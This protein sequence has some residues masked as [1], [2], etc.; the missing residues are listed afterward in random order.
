MSKSD[1]FFKAVQSGDT[2]RVRALLSLDPALVRAKDAE[3]K[4]RPW[5]NTPANRDTRRLPACSTTPQQG[6]PR[7]QRSPRYVSVVADVKHYLRLLRM[8]C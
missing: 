6:E 1:E 2:T 4:E 5:P 8:S 7:R 3:G